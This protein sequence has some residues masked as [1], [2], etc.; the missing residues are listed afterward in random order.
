MAD[1]AFE[2]LVQMQQSVRELFEGAALDGLLGVLADALLLVQSALQ[3]V[4]VV[5]IL[6][7]ERCDERLAYLF[8]CVRG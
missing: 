7:V 4:I 2:L 8:D 6:L 5:V 1:C 3:L